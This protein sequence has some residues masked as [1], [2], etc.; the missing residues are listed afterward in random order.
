MSGPFFRSETRLWHHELL[1]AKLFY[2]NVS[3]TALC[4]MKLNLLKRNQTV[5][6]GE[7]KSS[8]LTCSTGVLQGSISGPIL[9]SLLVNDMPNVCSNLKVQLYADD[10]I[11]Y[12]IFSY[13]TSVWLAAEFLLT[14]KHQKDCVH[15]SLPSASSHV[16]LSMERDLMW[17]R[18]LNIMV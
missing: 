15:V 8:Y 18:N 13:D 17:W 9:F 16:F 4:W 3:S 12:T 2:F 5:D 10:T 1:L 7:S 6:I 11:F 14:L